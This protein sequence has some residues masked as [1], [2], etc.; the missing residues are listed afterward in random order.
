M[1]KTRL[2]D[3]P[4]FTYKKDEQVSIDI[5]CPGAC[6]YTQMSYPV[7]Y[8]LFSRIETPEFLFEFNLNHK[9]RHARG[10]KDPILPHPFLKPS[11]PWASL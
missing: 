4:A 3:Y 11:K 7:K 6:D 10:K 5:N 8:E 9:I 1:D 2:A